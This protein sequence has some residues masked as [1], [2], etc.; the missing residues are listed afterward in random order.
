LP[1]ALTAPGIFFFTERNINQGIKMHG[2]RNIVISLR[3]RAVRVPA[4]SQ[5]KFIEPRKVFLQPFLAVIFSYVSEPAVDQ[6]AEKAPIVVRH[7][8]LVD[9]PQPVCKSRSL[10]PAQRFP[11]MSW[12]RQKRISQS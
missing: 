9:L 2:K 3:R 5:I 4:V 12:R 7:F 6:D 1:V 11:H 8:I 10:L